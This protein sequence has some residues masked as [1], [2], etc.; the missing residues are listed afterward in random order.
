MPYKMAGINFHKRI[1]DVVVLE[2]EVSV[3]RRSSRKFP[4]CVHIAWLLPAPPGKCGRHEL[5]QRIS[6]TGEPAL[7]PSFSTVAAIH[8]LVN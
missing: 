7:Q 1:L 5:A 8:W 4:Q 6:V 3:A 2:I